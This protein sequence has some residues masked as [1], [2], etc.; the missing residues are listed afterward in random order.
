MPIPTRRLSLREPRI[1]QQRKPPGL[2]LEATIPEVERPRSI[3]PRANT[4][5]STAPTTTSALTS[6][7]TWKS[8]LPSSNQ[9]ISRFPLQPATT[10]TGTTYTGGSGGNG[11]GDNTL[12]ARRRSFLPQRSNWHKGGTGNV[13]SDISQLQLRDSQLQQ[14]RDARVQEAQVPG[15]QSLELELPAQTSAAVPDLSEQPPPPL[16]PSKLS[17]PV[18]SPTRPQAVGISRFERL[19][20]AKTFEQDTLKFPDVPATRLER[21]GSTSTTSS[22]LSRPQSIHIGPKAERPGSSSTTTSQV[23]RLQSKPTQRIERSE[24][25]GSGKMSK[26]ETP[27]PQTANATRLER[28]ASLRQPIAS[29]VTSTANHSR[30]QSQVVSSTK[31]HAGVKQGEGN[32]NSTPL[33]KANKP[34]FSTFQQHYSP[35]KG[36]K[37]KPPLPAASTSPTIAAGASIEPSSQAHPHTAALKIELLQLHLLHADS[38]R[39]IRE[40][41]S[42]AEQQLYKQH[43][44]VVSKYHTLLAREQAVQRHVNNLA[45]NKLAADSKTHTYKVSN[46]IIN[47]NSSS[48]YD[49]SEQIQVLS[50]VIQDV[51]VLT[52]MR[53]GRYT[54]CVRTFEKWFE[55]VARVRRGRVGN[56]NVSRTREPAPNDKLGDDYGDQNYNDNDKRSRNNEFIDPLS[57]EWKEEVAAL[58]VKLE[59][60]AR[61]LDCLDVVDVRMADRKEKDTN[62]DADGEHENE[63]SPSSALVR[64][65]S[66]HKMLLASMV[67]ELDVMSAV[68]ADVEKL[69]QLWVRSAVNRLS[70]PGD[71]AGRIE[72]RRPA[73]VV[74]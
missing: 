66:G 57:F 23:S 53:G 30:H 45:L 33:L 21:A 54:S 48:A 74:G 20:S 17:R 51:A 11:G 13:S 4:V 22:Q 63:Y 42:S 49:F 28:S 29:R 62:A 10:A 37:T 65:V 41:E 39:A 6:A 61:E 56:R 68:E 38:L 44:F 71:A 40:W 26:P 5:S 60:Y 34:Q 16:S 24:T 18:A 2:E 7:A 36:P 72:E 19:G 1:G 25:L 58:G 46:N 73:W 43:N 3:K 31:G 64:A 14:L 47:N 12:A 9:P 69:E 55:H 50:R 67:E 8:N 52:D 27:K 70:P 59:L 15:P 32:K 35:K